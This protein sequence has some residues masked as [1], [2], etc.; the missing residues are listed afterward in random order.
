MSSCT[1]SIWHRL[2]SFPL[3]FDRNDPSTWGPEHLPICEKGVMNKYAANHEA[4]VWQVRQEPAIIDVFSKLWGTNKLLVS[5][6]GAILSPEF[7]CRQLTIEF[8]RSP[9]DA[10]NIYLPSVSLFFC[11]NPISM[12]RDIKTAGLGQFVATRPTCQRSLGL[13]VTRT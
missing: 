5:C 8:G 7:Y 9:V 3:G 11:S 1:C 2:E 13:T 12:S 10:F 6:A 4:W